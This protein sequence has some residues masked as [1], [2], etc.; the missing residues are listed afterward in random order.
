[1]LFL[2]DRT[3]DIVDELVVLQRDQWV[4]TA[5]E[6]AVVQ[7]YLR[8]ISDNLLSRGEKVE[9]GSYKGQTEDQ[10]AA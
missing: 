2:E 4:E 10:L 1:M 7:R 6:S 9:L 3:R 8:F 5:R